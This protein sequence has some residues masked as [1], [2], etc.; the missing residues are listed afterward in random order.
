[1]CKV[2]ECP[3]PATHKVV[4]NPV[5]EPRVTEYY[6]EAH[7]EEAADMAKEG[8]HGDLFLGPVELDE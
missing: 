6:C 8:E 2:A 4:F 5:G 7:A 3:R 1:M